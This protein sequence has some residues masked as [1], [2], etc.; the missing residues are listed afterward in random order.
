[1]NKKVVL[2]ILIVAIILG[3]LFL[4]RKFLFSQSRQLGG[5]EELP[6]IQIFV[7]ADGTDGEKIGCDDNLIPY[8]VATTVPTDPSQHLEVAIQTLLTTEPVGDR[9][10]NNALLASDLQI[11]SAYVD[12]NGNATIELSGNL[13]LG[14]V[15]DGPRIQNQLEKTALAVSGI[16]SVEIFINNSPLADLLSG[17]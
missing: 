6:N 4:V 9:E 13:S 7:T 14:G 1:M 5:H 17:K 3:S 16:K 8:E 12:E 2:I 15:C 10:M 11:S